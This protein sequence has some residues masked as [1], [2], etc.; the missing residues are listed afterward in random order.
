MK[1]AL[2]TLWH[3]R[4]RYLAGV[5][6]VAFSAVLIA[7]Q[8]GMLLGLIGAVAIPIVNSSA[9]VWVMYPNTA[10]CDLGRPIPNYWIDRVW[11]NDRVERADQFIQGFTYWKTRGGSNELVVVLGVSLDDGSLGPIAQLTPELRRLLSEPGAVVL[12]R[13]DAKRL[14]VEQVGQ[15][16]EVNGRRVRVCGFTRNMPS[17]SGAFVITSLPTARSMLRMRD[18]QTTYL[19]AKCRESAST[20]AVVSELQRFTGFSVHDAPDWATKSKMHW[21]KKTKAGIA[22]GFAAVLGLAVGASVTSQTLY[23]AV[24]A[25]L[26]ELAV[27][28]ALGIPRWRMA[29]FVMQQSVVVGVLGLAVALPGVLG[30]SALAKSLG[31]RPELP[32]WLWIGTATITVVMVI[33]SGLLALRSLRGVEPAT[34]LR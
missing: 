27:L 18:D 13:R 11:M 1:F 14:Q 2:A 24:T 26:R 19:L 32:V 7:M 17:I 29:S 10:A 31:A 5:F 33:L 30:L 34:L 12:D 9:D 20:A 15:E 8:V 3:D 25:S 28:S 4:R 6:A 16:G 22:L 21:M 23:A